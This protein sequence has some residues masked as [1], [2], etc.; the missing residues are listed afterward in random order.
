MAARTAVTKIDWSALSAKLKPETLAS[1]NAFRRRHADLIKT[2][3]ELKEVNT[4]IDFE[5]YRKVLKN[6]KVVAD[7]EKAF[8]AFKPATYD[9]SEQLRVIDQEQTKAVAAAEKTQAKVAAELSELNEL[10]TNIETARPVD[11]LTVDD[12]AKAYPDLD[13]TVEK[14]IKRGQWTVPGYYE[15][16]GEFSVGF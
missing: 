8:L 1:V 10:L 3:N 12:V 13:K 9:L 4:T 6:K 7:A 16:F 2:V 11:Q 5:Q 14:M 15:R